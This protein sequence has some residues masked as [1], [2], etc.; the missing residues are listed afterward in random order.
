MAATSQWLYIDRLD[1][2]KQGNESDSG[3]FAVELF[4]FL[5]AQN[6]RIASLLREAAQT[7]TLSASK[8][9]GISWFDTDRIAQRHKCLRQMLLY[10]RENPEWSTCGRPIITAGD[11]WEGEF[12]PGEL[13]EL[14]T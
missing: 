8:P 12:Q 5:L 3:V 7:S 1:I 9:I 4:R 13:S 6:S 14:N 10:M 11:I 2:L